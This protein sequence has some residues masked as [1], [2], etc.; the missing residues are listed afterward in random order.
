MLRLIR[1]EAPPDF[2]FRVV[3]CSSSQIC[4]KF[5]P[6]IQRDGDKHSEI[7]GIVSVSTAL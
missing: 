1:L 6:R 5:P 3:Q 7:G 2:L 4:L